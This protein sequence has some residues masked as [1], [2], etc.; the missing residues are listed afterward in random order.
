M[1]DLLVLGLIPGTNIT[2]SFQAWLILMACLPFA[3]KLTKPFAQR[4]FTK[5]VVTLAFCV[6]WLAGIPSSAQIA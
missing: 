1:Y 3:I 6:V 2:I 5:A 4:Q